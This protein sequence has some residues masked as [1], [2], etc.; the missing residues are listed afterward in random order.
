M[1]KQS[2]ASSISGFVEKNN[3]EFS[4][5]DASQNRLDLIT[6]QKLKKVLRLNPMI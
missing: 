3:V 2:E 4:Y 6:A 1:K 5:A